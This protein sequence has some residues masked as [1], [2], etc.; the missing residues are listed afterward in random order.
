MNKGL[1]PCLT[2]GGMRGLAKE[3]NPNGFN[4]ICNWHSFQRLG[5][6]ARADCLQLFD[7]EEAQEE[8]TTEGKMEKILSFCD[9]ANRDVS[10]KDM[11]K[12]KIPST[13]AKGINTY[14]DGL[15]MN[16]EDRL[17]ICS[18]I[19]PKGWKAQFDDKNAE[20]SESDSKMKRDLM[21]SRKA[22]PQIKVLV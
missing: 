18:F 1:V 21:A 17:R 20:L 12:R 3:L 14:F 13:H 7:E 9:K 2:D 10:K 22:F 5:L 15:K 8:K 6:R 11:K 16:D 4:E 19:R